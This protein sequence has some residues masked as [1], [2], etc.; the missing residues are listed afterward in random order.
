[1]LVWTADTTSTPI[2]WSSFLEYRRCW[3][4]R[5]LR[6]FDWISRTTAERTGCWR[7]GGS[8]LVPINSPW[9][10]L[11]RWISFA[12]TVYRLE[13]KREMQ[14]NS[15]SKFSLQADSEEF[16]IVHHLVNHVSPQS[17]CQR[18]SDALMSWMKLTSFRRAISIIFYFYVSTWWLI[19]HV[20]ILWC[21]DKRVNRYQRNRAKS[22]VHQCQRTASARAEVNIHHQ[23]IHHAQTVWFGQILKWFLEK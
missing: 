23:Y 17:I 19:L 18:R 14:Q 5:W 2:V 9:F 12:S 7:I 6:C 22:G 11:L 1:M 4:N 16:D 8:F 21:A 20:T 15:C 13:S 10:R 3:S